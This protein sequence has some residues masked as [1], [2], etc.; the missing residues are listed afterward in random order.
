MS[1]AP[2][3]KQAWSDYWRGQPGGCLPASASSS[4]DAAFRGEWRRIASGLPADA[5]VLDLATGDGVVLRW[6]AEVRSDLALI[7]VDLAEPLPLPPPGITT[8]GGVAMESLPFEAASFDAVVSQF[9]FEYGEPQRCAAEVS[10][11]LRRGGTLTLVTHHADG[12]IVAH[13]RQRAAELGWA[14]GDAGLI[15][16]ARA[17]DQSQ[18]RR[19]VERAPDLAI[20]RFGK[21]SAGW[22]IAEAIARVVRGAGVAIDSRGRTMLDQLERMARGELQRIDALE[23]ASAAASES[24]RLRTSL[25]AHELALGESHP[26]IHAADGLTVANFWSFTRR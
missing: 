17:A 20:A 19:D 4:L 7:G 22:Q 1:D 18:N 3:K 25:E 5:Q 26:I 24:G 6:L 12:P 23:H 13:N 2:D 8:R 9:G 10:R 14:L 11:V 21:G 16:R 15:E